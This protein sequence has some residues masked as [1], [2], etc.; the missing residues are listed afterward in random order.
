M[1]KQGSPRGPLVVLLL[2]VLGYYAECLFSVFFNRTQLAT[3]R[4]STARWD[5]HRC[6]GPVGSL[7]VSDGKLC[8]HVNSFLGL[9]TWICLFD[10]NS[11]SPFH[12][13]PLRCAVRG[14]LLCP[15][16]AVGC[17][18]HFLGEMRSADELQLCHV[19][20]GSLTGK[21]GA[22][23]LCLFLLRGDEKHQVL[24][25]PQLQHPCSAE[26]GSRQSWAHFG[27]VSFSE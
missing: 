3:S 25:V 14:R 26:P 4:T 19:P 9:R 27:G 22:C 5:K 18:R 23:I 6:Q 17:G 11:P 15:G 1:L 20:S 10:R 21:G 2:S 8:L 13:S 7:P 24:L 16:S 12:Q